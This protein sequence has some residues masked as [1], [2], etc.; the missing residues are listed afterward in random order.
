MLRLGSLE[1]LVTECGAGVEDGA[2]IPVGRD[3]PGRT[4]PDPHKFTNTGSERLEMIDIHASD[5]FIT[6]WLQQR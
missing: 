6:Q 5:V 2:A 1:Q 4:A 3:D